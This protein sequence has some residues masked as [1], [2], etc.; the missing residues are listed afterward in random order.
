M[1]DATKQKLAVN[2]GSS[3]KMASNI[4]S[5]IVAAIG[6]ALLAM[7]EDMRTQL[8]SHIPAPAWALPVIGWV[9]IYVARVWPQKSLTPDEAA[10]KSADA[11]QP[12]EGNP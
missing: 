7:P 9:A 8:L 1:E 10:A 11:P 6:T 4:A 2:V 3:W 5:G 12:P